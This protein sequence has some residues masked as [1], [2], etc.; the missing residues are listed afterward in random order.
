MGMLY[1]RANGT[2]K[3]W[4][5]SMHIKSAIENGKISEDCFIND[6]NIGERVTFNDIGD[7]KTWSYNLANI[8]KGAC[9]VAFDEALDSIY[10][11]KGNDF[12]KEG[13][14]N[15]EQGKLRILVYMIRCS[16]AHNPAHPTWQLYGKYAEIG[17]MKLRDIG[18]ELDMSALN[19][20]TLSDSQL[21]GF[22]QLVKLMEHC[23]EVIR[24]YDR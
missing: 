6:L 12:P 8:A 10:G 18:F 14:L 5:F 16:F 4:I 24:K 21:G 7:I 11:G 15:T 22:E 13:D 2:F 1:K 17:T 20:K 23:L 3:I 9:F 19:G